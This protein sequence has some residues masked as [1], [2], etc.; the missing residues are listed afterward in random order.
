MKQ[1]EMEW[2]VKKTKRSS[3]ERNEMERNV[4]AGNENCG[5]VRNAKEW[6]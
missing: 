5:V 4:L 3:V 6:L 1:N 2:K